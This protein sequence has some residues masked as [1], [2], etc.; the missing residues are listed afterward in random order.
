MSTATTAHSAEGGALQWFRRLVWLGIIANV[1]VGIVGV[2]A[3]AQVL[4]FLKLDPATPLVWPRCAAFFLILL[5]CFY[6][7]AAIDPCAHRFSAVFAVVCR[8]AGTIFMA[9][10]GGHYIIF[11]LFD[12]V[13]GAPQ[14]I[15]LYLAWQR[16]KAAPDAHASGSTIVALLAGLLAVGAFIWGAFQWLTQPILPAFASDEE[17][18]K[19]GSIGNDGAGGIPY[20]IWIAMPDVCAH[21]LPRP[22][23]YAAFGLLYERGRNPAIDPPI[24]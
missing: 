11:G 22:Q 19:Y 13:F 24:G 20:P 12:F 10:V 14:A 5:S 1:V 6:I 23:G 8:C 17:Y 21:H 9:V 15:C 2:A 7:P 3:P 4:A 18:F 16:M